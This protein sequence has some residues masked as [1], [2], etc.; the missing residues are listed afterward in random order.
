[1]RLLWHRFT[2]V[3]KFKKVT[4]EN[5]SKSAFAELNHIAK[6]LWE[7]AQQFPEITYNLVKETLGTLYKQFTETDDN[8]GV[9]TKK[10]KKVKKNLMIFFRS[11]IVNA[12][13]SSPSDYWQYPSSTTPL[14]S[15]PLLPSPHL[16]PHLPSLSPHHFYFELDIF[17]ITDFQNPVVT[18]T[19]TLLSQAISLAPI[20]NLGH[21]I[22]ALYLSSLSLSVCLPSSSPSVSLRSSSSSSSSLYCFSN[23]CFISGYL[24]PTDSPQNH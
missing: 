22:R 7:L 18:P 1:M 21:L 19:F 15:P 14:P 17:P 11:S 24:N 10:T 12:N 2:E 20:V 23:V 3:S 9:F 5:S 4:G 6:Y 16:P 13:C 8:T